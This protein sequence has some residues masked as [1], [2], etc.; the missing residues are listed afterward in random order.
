MSSKHTHGVDAENKANENKVSDQV[1]QVLQSVDDWNKMLKTANK[2]FIVK[3]GATFCK[4]CKTIQPV[5]EELAQNAA[6]AHPDT[7]TFC[8]VDVDSQDELLE[9]VGI[10]KYPTFC[11]VKNG[12]VRLE[13]CSSNAGKVQHFIQSIIK[14]TTEK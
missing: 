8:K 13:M 12:E 11:W 9:V 1:V 3:V 6:C 5:F 4:P 14:V 10:R 7:F 2:T